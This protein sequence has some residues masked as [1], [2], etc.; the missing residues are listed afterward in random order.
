MLIVLSSFHYFSEHEDDST[1]ADDYLISCLIESNT[2]RNL[3]R[4]TEGCQTQVGE[5]F[6]ATEKTR[7]GVL[8][9]AFL[10]CWGIILYS[11]S[12]AQ[13]WGW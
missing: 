4:V 13:P 6:A 10:C 5:V 3:E 9:D 1:L 8:T 7:S 12:L 11:E 2:L